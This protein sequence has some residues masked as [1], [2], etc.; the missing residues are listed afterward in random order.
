MARRKRISKNRATPSIED[1][2]TT[3]AADVASLG[4]TIGDVASAETREMLQSIRQRLDT[5]A[6]EAGIA[7]RMRME[8]IEDAIRDKPVVSVL[9]AFALGFGAATIL[10]R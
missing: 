6:E 5:I 2:L 8:M 4:N 10:R 1:E 3:L 9:T 7:T